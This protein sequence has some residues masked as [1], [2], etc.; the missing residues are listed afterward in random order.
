[1]LHCNCPGSSRAELL[2]QDA[3]AIAGVQLG[4]AVIGVQAR[5]FA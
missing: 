1:M 5:A 3:G 4:F 2:S